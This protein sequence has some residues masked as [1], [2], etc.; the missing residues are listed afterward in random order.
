MAV[1]RSGSRKA[2]GGVRSSELFNR[3][4][5]APILAL[6]AS[7]G[8]VV[9]HTGPLLRRISRRGAGAFRAARS[10]ARLFHAINP[11]FLSALNIGN[12]LTFTV[13]L[14]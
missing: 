2:P 13:E 9:L 7:E 11:D 10:R 6:H 4:P 8:E 3:K 1:R 12:T 14:G 5:H